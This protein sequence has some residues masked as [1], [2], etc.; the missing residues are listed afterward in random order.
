MLLHVCNY[1]PKRNWTAYFWIA[2]CEL[3]SLIMAWWLKELQYHVCV[4]LATWLQIQLG[5][6]GLFANSVYSSW[7]TL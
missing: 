2:I 1:A 7:K 6:G 3:V 4:K 5:N